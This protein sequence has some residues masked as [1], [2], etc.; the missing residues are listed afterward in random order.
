MKL[1]A[2]YA[3]LDCEGWVRYV[4][5]TR[6]IEERLHTHRNRKTWLA[7]HIILEWATESTW[8][9]R[10]IFWIA[11]YR[12]LRPLDNISAGGDGHAHTAASRAKIGLAHRGKKRKPESIAKT[13][14]W[15]RGRPRSETTRAKIRAGHLGK[16]PSETTRERMRQAHNRP[17]AREKHRR[18]RLGKRMSET[19]K[20]KIGLAAI[21]RKER[22][23]YHSPEAIEKMRQARI[24]NPI[25]PWTGK[26]LPDSVRANMRAAWVVRKSKSQGAKQ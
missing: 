14:A 24:N 19:A 6:N 4:G 11:F 16:R 17:E 25:R 9:E 3:L 15:L 21:R 1:V 2:I 8:R 26:K 20:E 22:G 18:G 23:P 12:C 10:E 5:V 7:G 13:A